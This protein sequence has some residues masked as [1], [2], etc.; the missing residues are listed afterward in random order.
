MKI[1]RNSLNLAPA[2]SSWV[3]GYQNSTDGYLVSPTAAQEKTSDYID[4][5]NYTHISNSY[6]TG[7]F[8]STGTSSSTVAWYAMGCY[9]E[10][11]DFLSRI[12]NQTTYTLPANTYYVRMSFRTFGE[13][14]NVMINDGSSALPYEP[15]NVVDWY[16]YKYKL[17]ASGAWSELDDKKTPWTTAKTK[18]KKKSV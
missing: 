16:G 13:P 11:K 17:R 12:V 5:H 18:R 2:I 9:D 3:D 4:V 7:D 14:G 6:E 8:P 1:Y 10:N 15:Y